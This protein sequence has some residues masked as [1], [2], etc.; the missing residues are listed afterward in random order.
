MPALAILG[1]REATEKAATAAAVFAYVDF[2]KEKVLASR[3]VFLGEIS[4]AAI[5]GIKVS[6]LTCSIL[7]WL[8]GE[9]IEAFFAG[10]R[11]GFGAGI[12]GRIL[13]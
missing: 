8:A 13:C 4:G 2:R 1:M 6:G 9:E 5:S 12:L 3:G 10:G 11:A 7:G